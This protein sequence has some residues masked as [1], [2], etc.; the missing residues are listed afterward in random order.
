MSGLRPKINRQAPDQPTD[1]ILEEFVGDN[2]MMLVYGTPKLF[3]AGCF[4]RGFSYHRHPEKVRY[5][6][7]RLSVQTKRP[8]DGGDW[9][10]FQAGETITGGTST[11][12]VKF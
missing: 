3:S 11:G 9:R 5:Y 6:E 12:L 7:L 2:W 8:W 10:S 4:R 1:S